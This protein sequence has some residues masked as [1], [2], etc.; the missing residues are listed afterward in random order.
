ANEADAVAADA[1]LKTAVAE[2]NRDKAD[3]AQKKLDYDRAQGLFKSELISK[4][5]YDARKAG[6]EASDATVA[7]A[8]ARIAQSKPQQQSAVG[9]VTSARA[10][11]TRFNDLLS[12]T[13][14]TAPF[15]GT[16]TNLPVHEGETVVVG[17]QNSPGSTIMTLSDL[18]VI[19]AEVRVDET[20]IVN[21][22]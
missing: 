2:L 6:Y 11:L 4:A 7:Q 21:V 16:I 19:T 1:A 15:D 8:E 20:D 13:I 12:K 18:S 10:T 3:L 9:H 22:K 17:I 5:D 14:Y